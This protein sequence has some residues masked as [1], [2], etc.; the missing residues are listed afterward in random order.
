MLDGLARSDNS[1]AWGA[2]VE[3]HRPLMIGYF[4]KIGLSE[5]N[6]EEVAQRAL[7]EF[8]SAYARGAYDRRKGRL[9]DWLFGI[10]RHQL[11]GLRRE[12]AKHHEL[13]KTREVDA[14]GEDSRQMDWEREW[15]QHALRGCFLR[16]EQEVSLESLE[17]FRLFAV[18]GV[19]AAEVARL[20][21]MTENAVYLN[22]R[23]VLRR[24]G[25]L[26]DQME[27]EDG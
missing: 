15:R 16:L 6:A 17:A 9:R 24:I 13:A 5:A 1:E 7:V 21:G 4:T 8:A 22:K 11:S 20:L 3:R 2:F 18:Q 27:S 12:D 10:A 23:R 14:A 19:P 25:E 26:L